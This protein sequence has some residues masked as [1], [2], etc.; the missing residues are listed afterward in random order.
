[1]PSVPSEVLRNLTTILIA[2][3]FAPVPVRCIMG[4]IGLIHLAPTR[5]IT[6]SFDP[7]IMQA[8]HA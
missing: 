3:R 5:F 6:N 2:A 8:G 1:M 7:D 4:P